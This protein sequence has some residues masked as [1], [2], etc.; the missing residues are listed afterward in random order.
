MGIERLIGKKVIGYIEA[1]ET[2]CEKVFFEGSLEL[3][4][5]TDK[6]GYSC[7]DVEEIPL[8]GTT[9]QFPGSVHMKRGRQKKTDLPAIGNL[10]EKSTGPGADQKKDDDKD[11]LQGEADRAALEKAKV[12]VED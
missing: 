5:G 12:F 7:L 1:T 3:T 11:D 4:P 10:G 8:A 6:D 2:T 9:T